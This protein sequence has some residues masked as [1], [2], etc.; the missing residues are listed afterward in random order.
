MEEYVEE[1]EKTKKELA[2]ATSELKENKAKLEYSSKRL[3]DLS[4]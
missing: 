1:L 4:E 3:L 2:K